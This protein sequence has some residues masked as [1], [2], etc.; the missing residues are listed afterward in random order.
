MSS[1]ANREKLATAIGDA[2]ARKLFAIID[3]ETV[4]LELRAAVATNSKTAIRTAGKQAMDT[5]LAPG[6]AG[7]AARAEPLGAGKQI[8]QLLTNTTP[9]ADL[10]KR[11][12]MYGQIA[13]ALTSIRGQEAQNALKA[14]KVAMQG[15]PMAEAEARR[16]A[17]MLTAGGVLTGYQTG[18]RQL[19]R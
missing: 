18:T 19:E 10:A 4:K 1:R 9:Q 11:Q 14:V 5:E 3:K 15:Q 12:K 13:E 16:I 8:V 2:Q 6:V 17:N 7:R